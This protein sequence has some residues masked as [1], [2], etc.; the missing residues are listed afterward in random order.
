MVDATLEQRVSTSSSSETISSTYTANVVS[1]STGTDSHD[2][3]D[4]KVEVDITDYLPETSNTADSY[5]FEV[6]ASYMAPLP[7]DDVPVGEYGDSYGTD[8]YSVYGNLEDSNP[9]GTPAEFKLDLRDDIYAVTSFEK[10]TP[11]N[12]LDLAKKV[13]ELLPSTLGTSNE[14]IEY[15]FEAPTDP[16]QLNLDEA[17]KEVYGV[18]GPMPYIQAA[19]EANSGTLDTP[20]QTSA[21]HDE[22]PSE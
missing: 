4:V 20:S 3:A 8:D 18:N 9:L 14:V 2:V 1:Y 19:S 22:G 17:G 15:N 7:A 12:K 13:E 6:D 11:D 5:N 16:K 21:P 10:G